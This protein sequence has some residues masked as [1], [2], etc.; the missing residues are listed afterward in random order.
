MNKEKLPYILPLASSAV[1]VPVPRLGLVHWRVSSQL[2]RVSRVPSLIRTPDSLLSMAHIAKLG[3]L[4]DELI[5]L[6]TSTSPQVIKHPTLA[7]FILPLIHSN[8]QSN[9][10]R[11]N[12]HRETALRTLKNG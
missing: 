2:S 5:T 9:P 6:L 3:A 11:F 12:L 8:E 7:Q 1:P 10:S 4:T